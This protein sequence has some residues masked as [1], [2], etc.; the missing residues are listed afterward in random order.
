MAERD[1][2]WLNFSAVCNDLRHVK[3]LKSVSSAVDKLQVFLSDDRNRQL[4]HRWRSWGYLLISLLHVIKEEMRAYLDLG[5]TGR[6]RKI[7]P[8]IP[9]L[10]Y[11]HYLRTELET[12][13]VA[14][15]GPMLHLDPNGRDC[16]RQLFSF[17]VAVIDRQTAIEFDQNFE[18]LVDKEAWLTVEVL[19]Q[20]RVYCAVL[21]YKD[22]KNMLQLALG[23]IS[24]KFDD[25]LI[26]DIGTAATRARVTR[27]LVRNYPCDL[28]SEML[29]ALVVEIEAW[30]KAGNRESMEREADSLLLVIASTLLETLTDLI[31]AHFSSIGPYLLKRGVTIL[32]FI[33]KSNKVRKKGLR[34]APAEFLISFLEL[35]QHHVCAKPEFCYLPPLKLLR[36]MKKLIQIATRTDEL[37]HMTTHFNSVREERLGNA[38]GFDD[39]G[40]RHLACITDIIFSHDCLVSDLMQASSLESQEEDLCDPSVVGSKRVRSISHVLAWETLVEQLLDSP[41]TESESMRADTFS[42][43]SQQ[44][45]S[46]LTYLSRNSS[47]VPRTDTKQVNDSGSSLLLLLSILSRHGDYY[48]L[49][50]IGDIMMIMHK[51]NDS[52]I[53]KR[54]GKWQA[55]ILQILIQLAALS[56]RHRKVCHCDLNEHWT[57]IWQNL[58]RPELPYIQITEGIGLMRGETGDAVLTLL[59]CCIS[60][61]L[62][63]INAI[64]SHSKT[65]WNLPAFGPPSGDGSAF[66]GD[67]IKS[68]ARTSVASICIMLA[69]LHHLQIPPAGTNL[70]AVTSE[71]PNLFSLGE[72]SFTN[73]DLK[74]IQS[75]FDHLQAQV[76]QTNASMAGNLGNSYT[77]V[78]WQT[79]VSSF[80]YASV[81]D[82]FFGLKSPF[83]ESKDVI[84]TPDL[85]RKLSA[86]TVSKCEGS[87]SGEE[88]NGFGIAFCML[89]TGLEYLSVDFTDTTTGVKPD[90]FPL[91]FQALTGKYFG[92]SDVN[93]CHGVESCADD[94][95]DQFER[96]AVPKFFKKLIVSQDNERILSYRCFPKEIYTQS[97]SIERSRTLQTK[98]N[99]LF[100]GLL[101]EITSNLPSKGCNPVKG[102]RILANSLDV[103]LVLAALYVS[104]DESSS[105]IICN[106]NRLCVAP[107]L[108]IFFDLIADYLTPSLIKQAHH[109]QSMSE[110]VLHTLRK[111]QTILLVLQGK[112]KLEKCRHPSADPIAMRTPPELRPSLTTIVRVLEESLDLL[113]GGVDTA[114]NTPTSILP[115]QRTGFKSRG[116]K[117]LWE[118]KRRQSLPSQGQ[119]TVKEWD[120]MDEKYVFFGFEYF[121]L[122]LAIARG[123][124]LQRGK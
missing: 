19:V 11:W 23:S 78:D 101:S 113:C 100:T 104:R 68:C 85:I 43:A 9:Q 117:T 24:P 28:K 82:S 84:L 74:L 98:V 5:S 103:G 88:F 10:R 92:A 49:N 25:N 106:E 65:L 110:S 107:L 93:W 114:N 80:I 51:L 66:R 7:R 115:R 4:V 45:S 26:G 2:E 75:L 96:L 36:E 71:G 27:Y 91:P 102:L 46:T 6:K 70:P 29:L 33:V 77:K 37:N 120:I 53:A 3:S 112:Q 32:D 83:F 72:N 35:Y 50:R 34:G 97:I 44:K 122:C 48:I 57:N 18:T 105:S 31:R 41:R 123:F 81:I 8:K 121:I 86:R 21:D 60:F 12:A 94:T 42:P 14:A 55:L 17:S 95:E 59:N 73:H 116:S 124:V 79:E 111:L 63:S 109:S 119:L 30:F 61:Q 64:E 52:L 99:K 15:D 90:S 39:H 118:S 54:I 40:I 22:W 16:I 58:L 20:Y 89:D 13:H 67:R 47:Q 108:K 56:A 69:L 76:F 62:V 38:L 1:G 87:H